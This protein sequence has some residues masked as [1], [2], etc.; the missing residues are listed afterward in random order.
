MT[1]AAGMPAGLP[2]SFKV[3][4]WSRDDA[5]WFASH[6]GRAHRVREA[7]PGETYA[8]PLGNRVFFAGEAT[9]PV[10]YGTVHA[11]LW[12]G[13]QTAE[14]V[15]SMQSVTGKF[16]EH[17]AGASAMQGALRQIIA[18]IGDTAR[19]VQEQAVV[20]DEIARNM[21]AVQK[22]TGEV[23]GSSKE[24]VLQGEQLHALAL[25]LE[26]LVRGFRIDALSSQPV[27]L[28]RDVN[29]LPEK[30]TERRRVA[31]G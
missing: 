19:S 15:T 9:E 2:A 13:E 8:R 28:T 27:L 24:A 12:S 25:R 20:S 10:E 22:I 31:R 6:P 3:T 4:P 14:A 29:A 5:R 26:Q 7:F 16:S 17:V 11:A 21:D 23:L 30:S 18:T 1:H